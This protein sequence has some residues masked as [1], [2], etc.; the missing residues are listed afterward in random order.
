[1]NDNGKTIICRCEDLTL[2]DIRRYIREEGIRDID[3]LRRISR[4]G[5]G[6]CQGKIC[7]NL[8][9]KELAKETRQKIEDLQLTRYRP[10][11]KPVS[12]AFFS[13]KP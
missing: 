9:L 3:T 11:T 10:P 8:V 5:M 12:L 7:L 6:A 13:K 2:D 4:C 1:M